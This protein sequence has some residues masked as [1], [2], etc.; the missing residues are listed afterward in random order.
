MNFQGGGF[1]LDLPEGVVDSSAYVF[2]KDDE[3]NAPPMLQITHQVVPSVPSDI[4]AFLHERIDPEIDAVKILELL[5]TSVN[6]RDN[7]TYGIA[8]LVWG[9][10]PESLKERRIYLFVEEPGIRLFTLIV[11]APEAKFDAAIE[12]FTSSMRSFAP[13]EIQR[14][15]AIR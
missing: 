13:N 4:D 9:R 11:K 10:E 2:V 5:E 14:L 12:Y 3:S 8:T 6:R 1:S 7:W 15:L